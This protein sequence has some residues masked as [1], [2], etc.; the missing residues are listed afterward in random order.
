MSKNGSSFNAPPRRRP[1]A[2]PRKSRGGH[3]QLIRTEAE[4]IVIGPAGEPLETLAASMIL[5]DLT[6]TGVT[7]FRPTRC[8]C[9]NA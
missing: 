4:I 3:V 5:S 8:P 1:R 2:P 7:V 6:P 9:M